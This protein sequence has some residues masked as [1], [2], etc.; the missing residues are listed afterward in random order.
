MKHIY[1]GEFLK[2][3]SSR[4]I[5]ISRIVFKG[6]HLMR[7][8]KVLRITN[9]RLVCDRVGDTRPSAKFYWDDGSRRK[10]SSGGDLN[11]AMLIV[12]E[13]SMGKP[14]RKGVRNTTPLIV[15]L[16]K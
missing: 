2:R 13:V 14:G 9:Q 5:P 3:L 8:Y 10:Y 4:G 12:S 7:T 1:F 16:R 15:D 11:F 6:S